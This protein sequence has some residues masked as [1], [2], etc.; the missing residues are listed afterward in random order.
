MA[1]RSAPATATYGEISLPVTKRTSARTRLALSGSATAR[2]SLPP[3]VESG[4]MLSASA[5]RGGT[6]R[7]ASA[8][9]SESGEIHAG[10]SVPLRQDR[11]QRPLG[12]LPGGEQ[13]AAEAR[14]ALSR[15]GLGAHHRL[16]GNHAPLHQELVRWSAHPYPTV[17]A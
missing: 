16:G 13:L 15:G 8:R 5:T 17:S 12:R 11:D 4:R 9:T 6:S 2:W 1:L 7:S 14:P 3:S 10:P